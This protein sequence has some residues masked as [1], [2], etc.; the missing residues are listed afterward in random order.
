MKNIFIILYVV[1]IDQATKF[2]AVIH[3][4]WKSNTGI[5]FGIFPSLPVWVFFALTFAMLLYKVQCR[6]KL[7]FGWSLFVAGMIGNL[8]DRIHLSYVIDWIPFPFP[9]IDRLYINIA[10]IAL[11]MG[12]VCIIM[13]DFK[14][15]SE[16]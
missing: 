6:T 9:F 1:T 8:I 4:E 7:D 2:L 16:S 3:L 12:F 13:S 15:P 10:D 11:I 14:N 5:S